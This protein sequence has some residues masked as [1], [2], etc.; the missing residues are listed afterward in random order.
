MEIPAANRP[1][2][3]QRL[4]LLELMILVAGF[5]LAAWLVAPEARAPSGNNEPESW[6]FVLVVLLGGLSAVGPPILL[7]ELRRRRRRWGA[8]KVVWFSQGIASWLLWPPVI[9][10]RARGDTMGH[11]MSG[12]CY[13]YGTPLMAIYVTAALLAGGW[14]RRGRGRFRRLSWRDQFGLVLGMLW[15]CTGFYVIYLLY[16]NDFER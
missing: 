12:V 3:R 13:F 4:T 15:A 16:R 2:R 9:Y 8:G 1:R 14:I 10:A 11:T 6:V 7:A 5:A